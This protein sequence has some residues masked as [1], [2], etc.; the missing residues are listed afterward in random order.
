MGKAVFYVALIVPLACLF[1]WLA[2]QK[3]DEVPAGYSALTNSE[4][5]W[6]IIYYRGRT[7]TVGAVSD[8]PTHIRVRMDG[9]RLVVCK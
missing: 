3:C 2:S 7:F 6:Q 5:S 4:Y 9:D 1:L 8:K